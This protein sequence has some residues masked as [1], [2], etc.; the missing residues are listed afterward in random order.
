MIEYNSLNVKLS[1][2]QFNKLKSLIKKWNWS[3]LRL[4]S[5]MVGN[6]NDETSSPHKLFL[7]DRQVAN[8]GKAFASYSS[9]EI[10][11][12]YLRRCNRNDV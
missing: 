7:T 8:L 12:Y 9:T 4:S 6:S 2:S 11:W 1:N 10:S 5:D 3:S